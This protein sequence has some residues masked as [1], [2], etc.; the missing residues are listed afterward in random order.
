ERARRAQRSAAAVRGPAG[1]GRGDRPAALPRRLQP[2]ARR[3]QARDARAAPDH[4]RRGPADARQRRRGEAA[5]G[6]GVPVP[7]RTGRRAHDRAC[8]LPVGHGGAGRAGGRRPARRQ[9]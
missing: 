2:D 6:G 7:H 3:D 4:R 5:A 8:R 1:G 9:V